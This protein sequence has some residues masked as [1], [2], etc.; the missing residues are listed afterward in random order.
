MATSEVSI[1][2]PT[3]NRAHV[4]EQTL[5]SYIIQ[6]A[7]GEIIIVDDAGN[8]NTSEVV[9]KFKRQSSV[10]IYYFKNQHHRGSAGAR[11][12]AI[13]HINFPF[14]VWGEDDIIF[15]KGYVVGLLR[16]LKSLDADIVGGRAIYLR[17]NETP[18]HSLERVNKKFV[19]RPLCDLKLM[20]INFNVLSGQPISVPFLHSLILTKKKW[21][22]R[23]KY[24]EWYKG[25]SYREETDFQVNVLKHGGKIFFCPDVCCFH[26][27]RS[28]VK[29]GGQHD[30]SWLN[31]EYWAIRNNN[32]FL[33][34]YYSL[35]KKKFNLSES[36]S[37]MKWAFAK[38][39]IEHY[40]LPHLKS[41]LI[42]MISPIIKSIKRIRKNTT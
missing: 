33:N 25:S 14:A 29:T 35:F 17:H 3:R 12:I 30:R 24:D 5:P 1:L 31:Y 32:Y 8:D 16:H 28:N 40:I 6:E 11:N 7:V 2:I 37:G 15:G 22:K 9:N 4:L 27:S 23:L 36:K 42:R 20:E 26:L 21:L 41:E 18:Q 34:K 38:H 10:P 39:R 13:E 19:N